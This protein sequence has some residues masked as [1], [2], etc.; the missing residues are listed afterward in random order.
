MKKSTK[1]APAPEKGLA[2][3]NEGFSRI[4][5]DTEP[6]HEHWPQVSTALTTL[7]S[8]AHK[9]GIPCLIPVPVIIEL[10]EWWLRDYFDGLAKVENRVRGVYSAPK[11][12]KRDS[13]VRAYRKYVQ[14][15]IVANHLATIPLTI[16]RL[17][18]T[19]R[20]AAARTPPFQ[21]KRAFRDG[22]IQLS[23]F[24]DLKAHPGEVGALISADLGFQK[25]GLEF[26]EGAAIT[27][28][29]HSDLQ[30]LRGPW[31]RG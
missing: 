22:V 23:I 14:H 15:T 4:Y 7:L 25:R 30:S 19:F 21:E 3:E 9:V 16:K 17:K 18:E 5:F 11:I 13:M 8:L 12:P 6:L 31:R 29:W 27:I 20:M 2:S 26:A 24:E 10:E 28:G 1:K